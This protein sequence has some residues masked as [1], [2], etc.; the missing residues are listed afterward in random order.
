MAIPE[1]WTPPEIT[2]TTDDRTFGNTSFSEGGRVA[3]G[4]GVTVGLGVG[5][6]VRVGVGLGVG[7][8][9]GEGDGVGVG[10]AWMVASI[11]A[12][13]V[14]SMSGVGAGVGVTVGVVRPP[15]ATIRRRAGTRTPHE[16]RLMFVDMDSAR[17]LEDYESWRRSSKATLILTPRNRICKPAIPGSTARGGHRSISPGGGGR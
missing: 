10:L 6:G 2:W 16:K 3:V 1:I 4:V 9:V 7:L 11:P 5:E 14:A 13:M 12:A 17:S 15:H 8:A